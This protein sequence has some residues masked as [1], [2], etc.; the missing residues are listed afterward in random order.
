MRKAPN[1]VC[2]LLVRKFRVSGFGF[3]VG[4]STL[5]TRNSQ[6]SV[7]GQAIV[8]YAILIGVITA[9]IVGM[10]TY[11]KRGIQ[12]T[13]KLAADQI[14]SQRQ[15]GQDISAEVEF[16]IRD[17]SVIFTDAEF[18]KATATGGGGARRSAP[19]ARSVSRGTSSDAVFQ[20]RD[21]EDE[22][23]EP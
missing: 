3:R 10:Q 20:T 2:F 1:S 8:E 18:V 17:N 21:E 15:G 11:A 7:G 23:Q 5:A 6:R 4:H 16:R 14:G 12:A 13:V 9:A 19:F 22:E